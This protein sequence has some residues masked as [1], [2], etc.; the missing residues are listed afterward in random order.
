MSPV[1]YIVHEC[2]QKEYSCV[3]HLRY[4]WTY[5]G[6]PGCFPF[7]YPAWHCNRKYT[8][9]KQIDVHQGILAYSILD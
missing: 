6:S 2:C 7:Y 8:F 3:V 9:L 4:F 5:A 1:E